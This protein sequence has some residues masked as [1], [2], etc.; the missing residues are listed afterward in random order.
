MR[1]AIVI[2]AGVVGASVAYHLAQAGI[3]VELLDAG[4]PGGGTSKAT[5]A[6]INARDRTP[7]HYFRLSCLAMA[8]H[9]DLQA[10]LG[11]RW[12]HGKGCIEWADDEE[13]R[14]LLGREV[15]RLHGWG[16]P[17]ERLA[18]EVARD[19]FE[20]SLRLDPVRVPW[21]A[22][23]SAD[24]Y[25]HPNVMIAALLGG[26][27]VRGGR[28]RAGTRVSDIDVDACGVWKVVTAEGECISGDLVVDCAGPAA[29]EVAGW[30]GLD[31]PMGSRPGLILVAEPAPTRIRGVLR[32]PAI[33]LRH[34]GGG[35]VLINAL[36]AQAQLDP[37]DPPP[38][39]GEVCAEALQ[40]SRAL[41]S[42]LDGVEIEAVRVG[43]RPMPDDGH[44]LVGLVPGVDGA[45]VVVTHSGVSL[46][47]LLG[48][49]V[50]TE[51]AEGRTVADLEPY[52]PDRQVVA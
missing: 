14:E 23:F 36:F 21:V 20:P 16:Y 33:E 35:R 9:R 19:R 15:E 6:W 34:D 46:A 7:E 51:L 41:V 40:R 25:I 43:I 3:E 27:R 48:R 18:T 44:P 10:Q 4:R 42:G 50:A 26:V 37:A 45:Y 1:K 22:R 32:S 12:Q 52:R 30:L 2:G 8:A 39:G 38:L 31:L 28:V 47:P 29:G 24:T 17:A 11:C 5:L 13:G 49:L